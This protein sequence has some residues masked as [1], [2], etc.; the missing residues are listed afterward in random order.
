MIMEKKNVQLFVK[1]EVML[2][3]TENREGFPGI[4]LAFPHWIW[5]WM[6]GILL[7]RESWIPLQYFNQMGT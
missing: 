6:K 2:L 1:S 5:E 4:F 7:S 3:K